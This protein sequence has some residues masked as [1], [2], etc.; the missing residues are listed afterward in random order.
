MKFI[1]SILEETKCCESDK[2][3]KVRQYKSI[4]LRFIQILEDISCML[5]QQEHFSINHANNVWREQQ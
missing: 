1:S 4:N 3:L 5:K 2:T